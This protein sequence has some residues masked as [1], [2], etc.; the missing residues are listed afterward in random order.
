[1]CRSAPACFCNLAF[2]A[3]H[4]IPGT[5]SAARHAAR[6][7]SEH[8]YLV[9]LQGSRDRVAVTYNRHPHFEADSEWHDW[10]SSATGHTPLTALAI[11]SSNNNSWLL[12]WQWRST[13]FRTRCSTCGHRGDSR[14]VHVERRACITGRL[15]GT[16]VSLGAAYYF[17]RRHLLF[18]LGQLCAGN[19]GLAS[20]NPPAPRD[21]TQYSVGIHTRSDQHSGR[22]RPTSP[23][24]AQAPAFFFSG[25]DS[26]RY[27]GGV[28]ASSAPARRL[29]SPRCGA[30]L[31]SSRVRRSRRRGFT[32][33][34]LSMYHQVADRDAKILA[35]RSSRACA[36]HLAHLSIRAAHRGLDKKTALKCSLCGPTRSA[37]ARCHRAR[38]DAYVRHHR[39]HVPRWRR[40]T[41]EAL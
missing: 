6:P 10:K 16:Q 40:A 1:M 23:T 11:S 13:Q 31:A 26:A 39:D 9:A 37:A 25:A 21:V 32:S 3:G 12:T 14:A 41:V 24:G 30:R 35:E 33:P 28:E 38:A 5:A 17:S 29:T 7:R 15:D 19:R 27:T 20:G 8:S 4:E 36:L 34:R 22:Q 18:F 2:L